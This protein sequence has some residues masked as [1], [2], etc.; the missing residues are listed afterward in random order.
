MN[1]RDLFEHA[2]EY[3]TDVAA[4]RETLEEHR[5]A[6]SDDRNPEEDDA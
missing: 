1:W 2:A 6:T 5:E 3:E 4:I